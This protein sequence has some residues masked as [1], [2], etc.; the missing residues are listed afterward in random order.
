MAKLICFRCEPNFE[1]H[2]HRFGELKKVIGQIDTYGKFS[3]AT[4]VYQRFNQRKAIS[5][6]ESIHN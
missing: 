2:G 5:C 4:A 6:K 1:Q 3:F